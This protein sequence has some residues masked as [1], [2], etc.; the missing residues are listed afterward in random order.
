MSGSQV[1]LKNI[2]ICREL[3]CLTLC[4]NCFSYINHAHNSW[5]GEIPGS[6]NSEVELSGRNFS[7]LVLLP[8]KWLSSNSSPALLILFVANKIPFKIHPQTQQIFYFLAWR[9][10]LEGSE[11]SAIPGA[12]AG[13]SVCTSSEVGAQLCSP[14]ASPTCSSSSWP[15]SILTFRD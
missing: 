2:Q 3:Q 13:L 15:S 11:D 12:L 8:L 10:D 5:R 14:P 9:T 1:W 4:S 7:S 6:G